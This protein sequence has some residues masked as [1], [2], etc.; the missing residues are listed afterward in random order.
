MQFFHK[1]H[2]LTTTNYKAYKF[3]ALVPLHVEFHSMTSAARVHVWDR[4]KFYMKV[5]HILTVP[6]QKAFKLDHRY[7]GGMTVILW[8][9]T[10]KSILQHGVCKFLITHMK[11]RL[12]S[13]KLTYSMI[14]ASRFMSQDG[15]RG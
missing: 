1:V 5:F 12:V 7:P 11:P 2:I 13:G 3:G 8:H 15:A 6:Y 10:L 9:V 4:T 14:S